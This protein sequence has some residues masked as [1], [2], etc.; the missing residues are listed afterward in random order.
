VRRA[1]FEPATNGFAG[2]GSRKVSLVA[3]TIG[4]QHDSLSSENQW[5]PLRGSY[6]GHTRRIRADRNVFA[7]IGLLVFLVF[8][9]FS[10]S[11]IT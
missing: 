10:S 2:G 3:E 9:W 6:T 1:G 5:Q 8:Y 7:P 11:A 4:L